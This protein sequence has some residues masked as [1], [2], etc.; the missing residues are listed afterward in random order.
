MTAPDARALPAR[1]RDRLGRDGRGLPRCRTRGS[2]R[3][4]A[5]KLLPAEVVGRRGAPLPLRERGPRG[6]GPQPPQHRHDLRDRTGGRRL[7]HRDGADRRQDTARAARR[8]RASDAEAAPDRRPGRERPGQGPRGGHRAPGPQA[9]EPDGDA[10]TASSR[11]STSASRSSSPP[12]ALDEEDTEAAT[13]T[14][15]TR[16]GAILGTVGYMSPE[17]ASGRELDFRSDQF[18]F[19][20]I[21]Y[22]LA[23]GKR[24]FQRDTAAET[25]AAIIQDE[26]TPIAA[27]NPK[28]PASCR[29]IVER[30]LV[31]GSR[32]ALRLDPGP[33]ERP[34]GSA[35]PSFRSR[36]H[37]GVASGARPLPVAPACSGGHRG[38]GP[39]GARSRRLVAAPARL[40]LEEPP[41]GRPLHAAHRLGGVR[42][43]RGDLSGRQ[44]RELSRGPRRGPRPL[45]RQVGGS[46]FLNLTKGRYPELDAPYIQKTGFTADGTQ[47]WFS[48]PTRESAAHAL[49]AHDRRR[50]ALPALGRGGGGVV[51]DGKRIAYHTPDPGD[52]L[53]VA[54]RTGADARQ[55]LRG[56]AGYPHPLSRLVTRRA[57]RL[58]RAR[59]AARRHGR[60]AD[61]CGR[62]RAR[63]D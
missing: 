42:D 9:R 34:G 15:A 31:E 8:G 22:E 20:V 60:L 45:G 21:L 50:A 27:L 16:P 23:T 63:A 44:V 14:H 12:A 33:R 37:S 53:F 5:I 17:Q 57:L 32:G 3:E 39:P 41:R 43:R 6:L 29:W 30:C 62:R 25:F 61:P 26:P 18:S 10:A 24:A 58:L 55:L 40:L 49:R 35:G 38:H 46:E 11:S 56:Q 2:G 59:R 19:G 51:P 52:P 1:R 47:V 48:T 4:V 28:A 13:A 7:L 54:D 36:E